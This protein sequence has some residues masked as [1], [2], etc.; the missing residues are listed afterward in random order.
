MSEGGQRPYQQRGEESECAFHFSA[1]QPQ[2]ATLRRDALLDLF[3]VGLV[4]LL[5]PAGFFIT[6]MQQEPM[7]QFQSLP[8]LQVVGGVLFFFVELFRSKRVRGEQTIGAYMPARGVA[9][10]G[11]VVE[12]GHAQVFPLHWAVIVAPLCRLR[13]GIRIS[14]PLAVDNLSTLF[15]VH[16]H[17]GRY[18]NRKARVLAVVEPHHSLRGDKVLVEINRTGGGRGAENHRAFLGQE[19]LTGGVSVFAQ[20]DDNSLVPFGAELLVF[21]MFDRP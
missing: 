19:G 18:A 14:Q 8:F 16:G 17:A 15:A 21:N 9:E 11:R 5:D 1:F 6:G 20:V 7:A 2:C 12:H 10:A 4:G 13:P 3:G